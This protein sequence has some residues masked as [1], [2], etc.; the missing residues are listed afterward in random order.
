[1]SRLPEQR[2]WDSFRGII[3]GSTLNVCRVE[4]ACMEGMPDV[5]GI[6]RRGVVFWCE[7]KAIDGW[8]ERSSTFPLNDAF[9]P[10]QLPFMRKWKWWNGH[11]FV[12]L[13]VK[14]DYYLLDPNMDLNK[15]TALQLIHSSIKTGRRA[16]CEHLE[17]LE[18]ENQRNAPPA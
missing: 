10:G 12:L 5:V 11:A 6:N 16:I 17:R 7:N 9:E 4:N 18:N 2:A 3:D 13:R 15:M 14:I 1:L 8:P